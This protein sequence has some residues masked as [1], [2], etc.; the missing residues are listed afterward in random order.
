MKDKLFKISSIIVKV[1]MILAS[2]CYSSAVIVV[3][4]EGLM[5]SWEEVASYSY[6]FPSDLIALSAY[7]LIILTIGVVITAII[8]ILLRI[9][10]IDISS[11][12]KE[13]RKLTNNRK[14]PF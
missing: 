7:F 8:W 5:H 9:T 2:V 4:L 1:L 6:I 12:E 3:L 14:F 11:I 10:F 13:L